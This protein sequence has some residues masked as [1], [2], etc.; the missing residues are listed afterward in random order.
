MSIITCTKTGAKE[1]Q[2]NSVVATELRQYEFVATEF[3]QNSTNATEE[4]L[5]C[6][7]IRIDLVVQ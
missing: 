1:L 4:S 5:G 2:T 3:M 6:N 7:R